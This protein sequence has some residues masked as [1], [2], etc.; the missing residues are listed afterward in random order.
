[1]RIHFESKVQWQKR[2]TGTAVVGVFLM[3]YEG[4]PSI[5]DPAGIGLKGFKI[6]ASVGFGT[7]SWEV[8][9]AN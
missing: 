2:F 4:Q 9:C 6:G 8:K 7:L 3:V 1:M 5:A